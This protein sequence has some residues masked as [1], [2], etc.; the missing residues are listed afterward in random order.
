VLRAGGLNASQRTQNPIIRN[1]EID[2]T[3][4]GH[5][6]HGVTLGYSTNG[7]IEDVEVTGTQGNSSTPPGETFAVELW[8]ADNGCEV[9][10]VTAR[11]DRVPSATMF[12]AN[13]SE[14]F[15]VEDCT[16][17]DSLNAFGMAIWECQNFTLRNIDCRNNRRGVNFEQC[18]YT[19]NTIVVENVDVR[20]QRNSGPHFTAAASNGSARI[21]YIEPVWDRS[22]GPLK[23][24]VIPV[25][26]IYSV[27][28]LPATQRPEDITVIIDG[29]TYTGLQNTPL[30][31]VGAVW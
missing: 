19:D 25:G 20:G 28:G 4:V 15:I 6:H 5:N 27:T 24:G 9:R 22:S 11:G 31:R 14:G 26:Q 23:I 8:H 12:G 17:T 3:G 10:R 13:D 16:F 18:G 21:T 2:G 29:K 30:L 1:I 7:L